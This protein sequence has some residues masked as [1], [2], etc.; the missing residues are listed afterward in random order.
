LS[1]IILLD[2]RLTLDFCL[3]FGLKT[4]A[5]FLDFW[6]GVGLSG[7]KSRAIFSSKIRVAKK[8]AKFS[9][10]LKIFTTSGAYAL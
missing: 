1:K 9:D 4:R 2:N 10:F 7:K 5:A 3:V 8:S 6:G